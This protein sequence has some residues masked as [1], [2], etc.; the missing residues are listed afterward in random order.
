MCECV[1]GNDRVCVRERNTQRE[2]IIEIRRD[3]PCVTSV[4]SFGATSGV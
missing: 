2:R 4:A 1:C 3:G